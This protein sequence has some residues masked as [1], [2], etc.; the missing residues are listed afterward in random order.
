MT[1]HTFTPRDDYFH[2]E[3][4]GG[5]WWAT[6]TAWY[7]CH[8]PDRGLGG[9]FYTMVRPNIGTVAGGAWVWDAS[10]H[11]PWEALYSANYTALQLSPDSDLN[12]CHLP[13]GVSMRVLEPCMRYAIGCED[14]ERFQARLVFDGVMPPEPLAGVGSTFGSAHHFDQ[15]GHVTGE[16]VVHGERIAI[17]CIGMRDRTWGR[18]P[19]NRPR[20]AA[21][22]MGAVD[23]ANG[24]LA[25]TNIRPDG[26]MIA[27]GSLR[28]DGETVNL[29]GG[30]RH[31]ER[32][33]EHGWVTHVRL[34][35]RD[36]QGRE[37]NAVGTAISR[38]IINQHTVIDINTLM[39]WDLDGLV[40]W[41]E[42]QDMWPV[43][44]WARRRR[45]RSA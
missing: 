15:L 2:F 38:L 12:D 16:L 14:G 17:D 28:R 32:D 6:E 22:V 36:N 25:V 4:M 37:L 35:G 19:E 18:R 30:E 10:A 21:Y 45:E 31:L 33:P 9:W 13:T 5:D 44:R 23:A 26:D 43:H 42:D 41:G 24:F 39:R 34:V 3:E 1:E 11:L 7:S 8:R 27:Y 20:Q 29:E 40:A